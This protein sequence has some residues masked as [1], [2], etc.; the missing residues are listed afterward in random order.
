MKC[1]PS[2]CLQPSVYPLKL[3]HFLQDG[4]THQHFISKGHMGKK[5]HQYQTLMKSLLFYFPFLVSFQTRADLGLNIVLITYFSCTNRLT[6]ANTRNSWSSKRWTT[7]HVILTDSFV[8]VSCLQHNWP[9]VNERS[10]PFFS[11][12]SLPCSVY[13]SSRSHLNSW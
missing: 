7:V 11:I 1:S 13:L 9:H 2:Y 5:F 8:P 6:S 4:W 10:F 3:D 12:H